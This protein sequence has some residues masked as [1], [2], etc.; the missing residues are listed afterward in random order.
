M[1][2]G[3]CPWRLVR[4]LGREEPAGDS[5][6][7]PA[8][9]RPGH[10]GGLLPPPGQIFASLTSD[11]H[12]FLDHFQRHFFLFLIEVKFMSYKINHLKGNDSVAFIAS[13]MARI[14]FQNVPSPLLPL[15]ALPQPQ[16]SAFAFCGSKARGWGGGLSAVLLSLPLAKKH[17]VASHAHGRGPGT[18]QWDPCCW[19]VGGRELPQFPAAE[20]GACSGVLFE[21]SPAC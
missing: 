5:G 4:H 19:E 2:A 6:Q 3:T 8:G 16:A 14:R 17:T 12:H 18:G 1:T 13:P 10:R 11:S 7:W 9:G 20:A 21:A 15:P